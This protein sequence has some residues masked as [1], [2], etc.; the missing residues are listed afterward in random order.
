MIEYTIDTAQRLVRVRMSGANTP[1]D[2]LRHVSDLSADPKF[3]A[4]FN[5]L[6][7]I[8]EDATLQ[9][10]LFDSLLKTFLEQ[11]QQRRKGVKWAVVSSSRIQLALAM[12]ATDNVK[13]QF[14][15]VRFF[16]DEDSAAKWLGMRAG[17]S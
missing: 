7:W 1:A 8:T 14:V 9:T 6:F 10:T 3:D 5:T 15:Q 16:D 12:L 2:L 4:T 11:W 13:F 17:S